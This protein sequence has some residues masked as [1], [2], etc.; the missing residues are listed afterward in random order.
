[1]SDPEKFLC[2]GLFV[3]SWELWRIAEA[4][5]RIAGMGM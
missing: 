3:I 5:R 1:M 2:Y 4:L